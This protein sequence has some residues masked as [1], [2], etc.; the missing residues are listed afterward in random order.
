MAINGIDIIFIHVQ[1]A[2]LGRG[3][4]CLHGTLEIGDTKYTGFHCLPALAVLAICRYEVPWFQQ[5]GLCFLSPPWVEKFLLSTDNI[6]S[7][8]SR[9]SMRWLHPWRLW[10]LFYK[11][12]ELMGER[13]VPGNVKVEPSVHQWISCITS[14]NIVQYIVLYMIN[15]ELYQQER[16]I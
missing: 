3:H 2:N 5:R 7:L 14:L 16:A 13:L 1:N 8:W 6:S 4:P 10:R 11:L 15:T 9:P 12:C